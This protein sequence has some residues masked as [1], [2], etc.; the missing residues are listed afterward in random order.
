MK[1]NKDTILQLTNIQKR[2]D[3][4][5]NYESWDVWVEQPELGMSVRRI[6]LPGGSAICA[7]VYQGSE[8]TIQCGPNKGKKENPPRFCLLKPGELFKPSN[9]SKSFLIEHLKDLKVDLA[10]KD[11]EAEEQQ[12]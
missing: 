3:F 9:D 4:V 11:K 12:A 2:E 8:Y 1:A 10:K 5:Q 6:D 7:T